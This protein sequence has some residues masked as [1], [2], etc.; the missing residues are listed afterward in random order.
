MQNSIT[1][2]LNPKPDSIIS[3]GLSQSW[4]SQPKPSTLRSFEFCE[5]LEE[6]LNL[7]DFSYSL[8]RIDPQGH[9]RRLSGVSWVLCCGRTSSTLPSEI[10]PKGLRCSFTLVLFKIRVLCQTWIEVCV[11]FDFFVKSSTGLGFQWGMMPR[12]PNLCLSRGHPRLGWPV[13]VAAPTQ[14]FRFAHLARL[15]EVGQGLGLSRFRCCPKTQNSSSSCVSSI[16]ESRPTLIK[17]GTLTRTFP[18]TLQ[19]RANQALKL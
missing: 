7:K 1:S 17:I 19:T 10:G 16:K 11:S 12:T 3:R 13:S 18:Q 6:A 8:Q 5:F 15:L 14:D 2:T 9:Q 4:P